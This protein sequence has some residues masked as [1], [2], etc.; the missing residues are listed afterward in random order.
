MTQIRSVLLFIGFSIPSVNA[1]NCNNCTQTLTTTSVTPIY[2][3]PGETLCIYS[4]GQL[5]ATLYIWGGEVCNEGIINGMIDMTDGALINNGQITS[6]MNI[7]VDKGV[8]INNGSIQANNISMNG[9]DLT[10]TN[11]GTINGTNFQL[12]QQTT[13]TI[14][15]FT[16]YGDLNISSF[17]S[18]STDFF[19]Y[20][21]VITTGQLMNSNDASFYNYGAVSVG[22]NYTNKGYF[23]T[24]CMIPVGGL[25]ANNIPGIISGPMS[26]CGGFS[27][28]LSTSNFS[29]FGMD[30]SYLDMCDSSNPGSFNFNSGSIGPNVTYCSCTALCS[31]Q[32]VAIHDIGEIQSDRTL[33]KIIDLMG[34]E[35]SFKPNTPLIYLYSDGTTERVMKIEE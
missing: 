3:N 31:A 17:L 15:Q 11:N 18:D 8:F 34:R 2:V 21:S 16:N 5:D 14:N 10:A 19:N 23:Y 7:S 26:G 27:A 28:D 6:G 22:A 30:G 1:Q 33:V 32:N 13:G 25:W 29:D 9:G 4:S 20:G 35:T 24:E 12:I